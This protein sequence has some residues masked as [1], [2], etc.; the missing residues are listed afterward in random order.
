[1]LLCELVALQDELQELQQQEVERQQHSVA[2]RMHRRREK[3]QHDQ[4]RGA[5]Q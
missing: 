1:M 3:R 5:L 2:R 4:A